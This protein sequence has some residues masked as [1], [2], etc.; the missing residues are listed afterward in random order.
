MTVKDPL[1]ID[2]CSAD[3]EAIIALE[4]DV[5]EI[6]LLLASGQAAALER[7]AH[8]RGLSVAQMARHLIEDFLRR[9]SPLLPSD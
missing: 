7:A 1:P 2:L 8:Q 3:W 6:P 4:S 9:T 5:V